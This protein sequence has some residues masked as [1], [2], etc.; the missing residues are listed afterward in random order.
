MELFNYVAGGPFPPG[1]SGNFKKRQHLR[2]WTVVLFILTYGKERSLSTL[3]GGLQDHPES[4]GLVYSYTPEN[5][6]FLVC[7]RTFG[8]TSFPACAMVSYQ[9]FREHLCTEPEL[10]GIPPWRQRW[11]RDPPSRPGALTGPK[12]L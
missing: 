8:I 3:V 12:P 10:E 9:T 11:G 4:C 5:R 2:D 7:A 6:D 1:L